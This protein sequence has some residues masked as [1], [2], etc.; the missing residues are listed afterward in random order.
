VTLEE[1]GTK[2]DAIKE[3]QLELKVNVDKIWDALEG[4]SHP[5]IKVRL[6]RIEQAHSRL[7]KGALAFLPFIGAQ[8]LH[9]IGVLR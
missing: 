8:I 3:W 2:I 1:L 6:D 5:G 4:N 7:W 9:W